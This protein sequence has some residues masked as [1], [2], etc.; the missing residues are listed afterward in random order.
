MVD[1]P[2]TIDLS[3]YANTD[4]LNIYNKALQL[5]TQKDTGLLNEGVFD[6]KEQMTAWEKNLPDLFI[7]GME[8]YQK[9]SGIEQASITEAIEEL[10]K[11]SKLTSPTKGFSSYDMTYEEYLSALDSTGAYANLKGELEKE[12][13]KVEEEDMA[14]IFSDQVTSE[15]RNWNIVQYLLRT[16]IDNQEEQIEGLYNFPAD[17]FAFVSYDAMRMSKGSTD[18][19]GT[20]TGAGTGA[21]NTLTEPIVPEYDETLYPGRSRKL[22]PWTQEEP[23]PK[24]SQPWESVKA[25]IYL[26]N[27]KKRYRNSQ[28]SE[29]GMDYYTA[30]MNGDLNKPAM[31][32]YGIGAG[33]T[34]T[35]SSLW[36]IIKGTFLG[37]RGIGVG[38]GLGAGTG[39][40]VL[41]NTQTADVS[42]A[43]SAIGG[44]A[45]TLTDSV[46]NLS[47]QLSIQIDNRTSLIVDGR[48]LAQIVKRHMKDDLVRYGNAGSAV[49]RVNVI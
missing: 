17:M 43:M 3:E 20:G 14:V 6:S 21:G 31:T 18:E 34:G 1:I 48:Q 19:T 22:Y 41:G 39:T 13:V 37:T 24:P 30:K 35:A 4:L 25:Q 44:I 42:G 10:I 9:W 27:E 32:Q 8:D 16:I 28:F 46:K 40:N 23:Y 47:T 29:G 12:G 11:S 26:A 38:V 45:S 7:R 5:Q 15:K 2:T 36:D 49:T 33:H